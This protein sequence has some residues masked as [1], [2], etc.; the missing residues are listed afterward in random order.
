MLKIGTQAPD[1]QIITH[2]GYE[3][4]LSHFWKDSHLI[5]FFYPKDQ[6][7]ICTKQACTL[8][9][10]LGD[11]ASFGAGVLGSST[12][13]VKQHVDFAAKH[14][15]EFPLVADTKG[16]LARA[17]EAYRSLIRIAKRITY[18]I[19]PSGKIIGT[20]HSELSVDGHLNMIRLA[21][22]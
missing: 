13:G 12:D 10:S 7:R 22:G 5:L 15:L 1:P 16:D 9:T 8:Q 2:L 18:V 17:F 21:L 19:D 6:T 20:H 3:G 11:F 4:P 14:N